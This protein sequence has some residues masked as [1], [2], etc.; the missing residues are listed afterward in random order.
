MMQTHFEASCG[1]GELALLAEI[2]QRAARAAGL[3]QKGASAW[4]LA[5]TVPF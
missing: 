3:S 2:R 1:R 4:V 5:T